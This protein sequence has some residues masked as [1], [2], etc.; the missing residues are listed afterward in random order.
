MSETPVHERILSERHGAVLALRFNRP[1]KKNALT[2]NMYELMLAQLA[3]AAADD[4]IRVVLIGGAG[5]SFTAGNDLMDF[6]G[7]PPT[8]TDSAVFRLLLAL[9]DFDK[10]VVT[11]VEG[12]AVGI[13][14]TMLLHTDLNY[15][16]ADAK[17]QMPFVSLGLCPEAASSLLLPQIMGFAKASELLLLSERFN[18]TEA[19]KYGLVNEAIE[20]DV[21]AHALAKAQRL[22][23]M[24]PQ[25][26]RAS[27]KLIRDPVREKVRETFWT[28]G[29]VFIERLGSAEAA[30]AF[31]AF[32]EKRKPNFK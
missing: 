13:G 27:K 11:A 7:Q 31:Q 28:E 30:E 4:S 32:F 15:A 23:E 6:M 18:G 2:V 3:A 20:G 10:P 1:E 12:P 26:V 8:G 14:V 24:A 19:A 17:F 25:S 9:L 21:F 22:A 16:K 5:G 29:A